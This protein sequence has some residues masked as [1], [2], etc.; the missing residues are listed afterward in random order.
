M[1]GLYITFKRARRHGLPVLQVLY[2]A[3]LGFIWAR[4]IWCLLRVGCVTGIAH[5]KQVLEELAHR[6]HVASMT[7]RGLDDPFR[8]IS[9]LLLAPARRSQL[10]DSFHTI[11]PN[12]PYH[13]GNGST[14]TWIGLSYEEGAPRRG[15]DM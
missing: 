9:S 3:G 1:T 5:G 15:L 7:D 4:R 12:T 13:L 8:L 11:L 10:L 14:H 2:T 6:C